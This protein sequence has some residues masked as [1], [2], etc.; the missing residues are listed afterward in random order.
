[1]PI[2][3]DFSGARGP[4]G[5]LSN[6]SNEDLESHAGVLSHPDQ[7]ALW[8]GRIVRKEAQIESM[9][10]VV[11]YELSGRGLSWA[12]VPQN[13]APLSRDIRT[14]LKVAQI[15]DPTYLA[16][17]LAALDRLNK[18]HEVR[19][20]IVHDQWVEHAENPGSFVNAPKGVTDGSK[21]E[22]VWDVSEFE[23]CYRELRFC[24]AMI[25]GLHWSISCYVGDR[26]DFFQH[27]LGSNREALAGRIEMTGENSWNFTDQEFARKLNEEMKRTGEEMRARFQV[28][29]GPSTEQQQT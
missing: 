12:V 1:L 14:M 18:A 4:Q 23:R 16:D 29:F 8:A 22:V 5:Y 19:N 10:R 7:V 21:A 11:F 20:R 26:R 3:R 25:S 13:F 9:L 28:E 6:V 27:M 15:E 17:C 24:S 2:E